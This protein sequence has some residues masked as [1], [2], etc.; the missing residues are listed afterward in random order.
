MNL[1]HFLLSPSSGIAW[2]TDPNSF[3]SVGRDG[4]L[5]RH[6]IGDG[7]QTA[8]V[9][10]PVALALNCRGLVAH[11]LGGEPGRRIRSG[12]IPPVETIVRQITATLP[13]KD[14]TAMATNSTLKRTPH[15]LLVTR[16]SR[17]FHLTECHSY[18]LETIVYLNYSSALVFSGRMVLLRLLIMID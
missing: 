1:R 15:Q 10:N 3:Y 13:F 5:I 18:I 4:L 12:G 2:S 17:R 8:R 9:A 7:I 14:P 6:H 16:R 11:A